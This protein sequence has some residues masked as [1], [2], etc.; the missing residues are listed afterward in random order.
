MKKLLYI[1]FLTILINLNNNSLAQSFNI[2]NQIND[3]FEYNNDIKIKLNPGNWTVIRNQSRGM[4]PQKIIGIGRVEN[5][6]I[7]EIIE[8][9]EGKLGG[10]YVYY[11]DPILIEIVFKDKH[12]GCYERAEYFLL[13]LYKKG[14]SFNCMIVRHMDVVK[15]LKYPDGHH[16][17]AAAAA[18]N[19]W[20]NQN[21][22]TYPKILFETYHTYFSRMAG[23]KW[24]EVR[25]FIH[26]KLLNAPK[27]KFFTEETSEYHKNNISQHPQHQETMN[28]WVSMSSKFHKEFENMVN[29]KNLHKLSLE[30]NFID[31]EIEVKSDDKILDQLNKLNELFKSGVL[32]KEE[33]EKAKKKILN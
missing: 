24:Y 2:G 21:S 15:E 18:Y 6:E 10:F 4:P 19:F 31:N 26:P 23:G 9:Y 20:I 28:K 17:K 11:I 30:S 29:A 12:D 1:F 3:Y 14:S 8:V 5:N 33:F 16:G 32:T 27:S 25:K 22:L 7:L 13:E